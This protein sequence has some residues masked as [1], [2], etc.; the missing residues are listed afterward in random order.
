MR[1]EERYERNRIWT[2]EE[3]RELGKKTVAVIGCGGLGGYVI[4]MLG[5][6]GVG[7][8]VACDGD[9]FVPSNLNR[10]L[11][12]TEALMGTSKAQAAKERMQAV[13]SGIRVTVRDCF[14]DAE[15]GGEILEG[16]DV[17]VDALDSPTGKLLLQNL[18]TRQGIPLVHGAVHGWFGQVSTILPGDQTLDFL[19]PE[20]AVVSTE[21]GNPSFT[22]AMVAAIQ[23]GEAAKLLLGKGGL[24]RGEVLLINLLHGEFETLQLCG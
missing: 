4:E 10:Q 22:P 14:L 23:A 18:C 21:E 11:L 16:C 2:R 1:P 3:Q 9:V 7:Q 15:N 12:S 20:G 13:N 8:I 5:R 6:M 19:Y 24:L 17:A